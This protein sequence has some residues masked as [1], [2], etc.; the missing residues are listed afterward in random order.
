MPEEVKIFSNFGS[1]PR[2]FILVLITTSFSLRAGLRDMGMVELGY[3]V[4]V[5]D[6]FLSCSYLVYL[7]SHYVC[8][9]NNISCWYFSA[10]STIF[11]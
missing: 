5:Y 2:N 3:L 1:I 4:N 10:E 8:L 11:A 9:S 7:P 6:F